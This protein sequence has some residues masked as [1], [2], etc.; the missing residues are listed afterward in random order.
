MTNLN[1]K[2]CN[3]ED[4]HNENVCEK[5]TGK[6]GDCKMGFHGASCDK[7]NKKIIII[8]HFFDLSGLKNQQVYC[9]W[10]CF[11]ALTRPKRRH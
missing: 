11:T 4:G 6:C 5:S 10:I 1:F 3:C 2:D 7:G 9:R 8:S